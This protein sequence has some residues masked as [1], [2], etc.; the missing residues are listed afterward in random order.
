LNPVKHTLGLDCN[1]KSVAFSPHNVFPVDT[2]LRFSSGS[3]PLTILTGYLIY[4]DKCLYVCLY[5]IQIHISEPIGTKLCT[6]LPP[7][8]GRDRRACM[9]PK[10]LSS[11]TFWALFLY[12]PLQNHGHKMAA[13]AAVFRDNLISVVPA[14]VRVTGT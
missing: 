7:W 1:V 12:G 14:G 4:K 9:G 5:F 10:F 6:H 13:G 11:S 2:I 8:S 3:F